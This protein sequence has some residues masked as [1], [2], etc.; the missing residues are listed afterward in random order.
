MLLVANF[1]FANSQ[2]RTQVGYHRCVIA[3]HLGTYTH[4]LGDN[5]ESVSN[6]M[7]QN[8]IAK[9]L[10][11]MLDTDQPQKLLYISIDYPVSKGWSGDTPYF[12]SRHYHSYQSI[13]E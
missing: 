4:Q 9:Q 1:Q 3:N 11:R 7:A 8:L 10:F 12:L 5:L 2:T 13:L 6:A